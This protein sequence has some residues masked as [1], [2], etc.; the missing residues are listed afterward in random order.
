MTT[1][2]YFYTQVIVCVLV[3]A[4]LHHITNVNP[5]NQFYWYTQNQQKA[6]QTGKTAV[7][8][9][10]YLSYNVSPLQIGILTKNVKFVIV[11]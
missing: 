5:R 8:W 2:H 3:F 11:L 1:P 6:S 9:G 7:P 10:H 4:E